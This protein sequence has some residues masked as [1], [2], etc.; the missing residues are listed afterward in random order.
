[1]AAPGTQI[2]LQ[3]LPLKVEQPDIMCLLVHKKYIT[4]PPMHNRKKSQVVQLFLLQPISYTTI[5]S[6]FI[7]DLKMQFKSDVLD[8]EILT[9]YFHD[10]RSHG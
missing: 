5:L 1:M 6:F 9:N 7:I 10:I 4:L 2:F 8:K 3:L